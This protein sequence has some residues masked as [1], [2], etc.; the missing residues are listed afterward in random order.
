VYRQLRGTEEQ[1]FPDFEGLSEF[2]DQGAEYISLYPNV[3]LGA[4]RDHAFAI[5][6]EPVATDRTVEH[7]HFYYPTNDTD[8]VMRAKNATLWKGVFEEDIGVIEGMQ[9]GRAAPGFDGG[10]FSPV[11]DSPTHCF[12]DWV[13]AKMGAQAS[14]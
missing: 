6:L 9:R 5:V 2:W 8:E 4:Q 1:V 7:V 12:H 10:R 11:M 13:A 14:G 3:L